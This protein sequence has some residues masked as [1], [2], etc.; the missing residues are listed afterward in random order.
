MVTL[1]IHDFF[2]N[3][4]KKNGYQQTF[5]CYEKV[6]VNLACMYTTLDQSGNYLCAKIVQILCQKCPKSQ[7]RFYCC[8]EM[9]PQLT[10]GKCT[11]DVQCAVLYSAVLHRSQQ[12]SAVQCSAVQCSAV[13]CSAVQCSAV[14]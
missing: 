14:Q 12:C 2:H 3:L 9:H 5:R 10:A 11:A 8:T 4:L 7:W 13:Q 6:Q 1:Y